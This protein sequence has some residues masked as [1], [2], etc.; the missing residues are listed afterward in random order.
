MAKQK[1]SSLKD[2]L[3]GAMASSEQTI[4]SSETTQS[5]PAAPTTYAQAKNLKQTT[6]YLPP[7][8]HR[9]LRELAFNED[10]K[11]H[12]LLLEALDLLFLQYGLKSI[13]ELAKG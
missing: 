1:R 11:A 8:V 3:R 4:K 12:D 7:S 9:Q 6:L 5:T 13:D 10:R 2:S